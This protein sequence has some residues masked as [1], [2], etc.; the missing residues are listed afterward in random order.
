[1]LICRIVGFVSH[2]LSKLLPHTN[3]VCFAAIL[4][5]YS[6]GVPP[7]V[8]EKSTAPERPPA[9]QPS[10]PET[11]S[12]T[13]DG[14]DLAGRL[15]RTSTP[16]IVHIGLYENRPKIFTD[17]TGAAS[18]VFA[19]IIDEIARKEGWQLKYV[20]CEWAACLEALEK[21]DIQ[22]MPDVA[23]SQERD[24]RFDFHSETVVNSWS[25]VYANNKHAIRRLSDLRG[26]PGLPCLRN[27]YKIVSWEIW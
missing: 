26:R 15:Q 24:E 17:E 16:R 22:L 21:R 7:A 11:H 2:A 6:F 20:P 19:E 1:M 10:S 12:S 27:P 3:S 8:A 14:A 13:T 9:K 4:I 23:F 25:V 5:L 18:G